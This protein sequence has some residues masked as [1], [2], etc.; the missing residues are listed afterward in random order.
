FSGPA[1]ARCAARAAAAGVALRCLERDVLRYEADP[2][3]LVVDYGCLHNIDPARRADYAD[4]VAA[5]TAPGGLFALMALSPRFARVDWRLLG[6]HH[7]P[8]SEVAALFGRGFA[9]EDSAE[10]AHYWEHAPRAYRP[11]SG[12]F[13]GRAYLL[14]RRA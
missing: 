4:R 13:R 14:R 5:L 2:Y 3:D 9:L 6:P 12:P 10:V 11:L 8:P 1:V 7:L